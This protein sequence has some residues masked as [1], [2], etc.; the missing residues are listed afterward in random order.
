MLKTSSEID[1]DGI[2]GATTFDANGDTSPAHFGLHRYDAA[3]R[4]SRVGDILAG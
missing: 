3:G 4:F 2:S 1:Y